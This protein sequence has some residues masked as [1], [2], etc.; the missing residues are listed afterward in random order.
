MSTNLSG[1]LIRPIRTGSS[2][3]WSSKLEGGGQR[4][5]NHPAPCIPIT[6]VR[7]IN[8]FSIDSSLPPSDYRQ[9]LDVG[10]LSF[11]NELVRDH[12]IC[13]CVRKRPINKK[14]KPP[15]PQPRKHRSTFGT[16]RVT[17]ILWYPVFVFRQLKPISRQRRKQR[18][19]M[20]WRSPRK[21][22]LW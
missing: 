14:G 6:R 3:R 21:I 19:L 1:I 9:D 7:L 22:T 11:A 13:V 16:S 20:W 12:R 10:P 8:L 15:P 5:L 18:P 2:H 4:L 17:R